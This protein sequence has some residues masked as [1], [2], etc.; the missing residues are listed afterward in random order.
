MSGVPC[1]HAIAVVKDRREGWMKW[2]SPYFT[3]NAYRLAY[4]GYITPIIDVDD[5]GQPDRL[6]LPPPKQKAPGRP[7]TQRIRGEDEPVKEKKKQMICSKCKA[8]GHNKRTC[9]AR[10]DP[11]TVYKRK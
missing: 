10:N 1:V 3:V 2:C 5:W 9:D 7:K 4:E 11:T 8:T 6:V